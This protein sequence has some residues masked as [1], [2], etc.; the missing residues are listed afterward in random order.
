MLEPR[1]ADFMFA[2]PNEFDG[3]G[4]MIPRNPL[5]R[6]LRG[7]D[8]TVD[9]SQKVTSS[10]GVPHVRVGPRSA[11]DGLKYPAVRPTPAGSYCEYKL[12]PQ[13]IW[14]RSMRIRPRSSQLPVLPVL[15][16]IAALAACGDSTGPGD[17]TPIERLPRD[18]TADEQVVITRS[19]A[20][21]LELLAR[22]SDTDDRP[23]IVLSP[24]SASMALGMTLNGAVD[25]TRAAMAHALKF[26]GLDQSAVNDVYRDLIDLLV[27]LDPAVQMN[28]ANAIWASDRYPFNQDFFDR[29]VAAFGARVENA[30]FALPSTVDDINAWV[31]EKTSGKI[32]KI[33][34]RIDPSD[35]MML[36]NAI[37]F[38]GP[39]SQR[40]DP[41]ETTQA[42]FTRPD[43]STVTVDMMNTSE[44]EFGLGNIDGIRGRGAALRWGGLHAGRHAARRW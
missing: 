7:Q 22:V 24:L 34:E 41:G 30:D 3:V 4:L 28:I 43:G 8:V 40:F 32:D 18:L 33:V 31:D 16:A 9:G 37:D 27:T 6:A 21:G 35:A 12:S 26:E 10:R 2:L 39:W 38:D 5:P 25:S 23:N 17:A 19:N 20:F 13:N 29:V 14:H 1:F 36:L 15:L 42:P 11:E 44:G